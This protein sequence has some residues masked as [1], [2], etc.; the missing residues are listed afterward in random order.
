M[1]TTPGGPH[2]PRP[3]N[4]MQMKLRANH[5]VLILTTRVSARFF[6]LLGHR[7]F[8]ILVLLCVF[9]LFHLH[10]RRNLWT[11]WS[12]PHSTR[13]TIIVETAVLI[14]EEKQLETRC[15]NSI[16]NKKK[17]CKGMIMLKESIAD[18][19]FFFSFAW[20]KT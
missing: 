13:S 20:F 12:L 18:V 11:L 4:L 6:F 16:V 7:S 8:V 5:M 14:Y 19:H 17:R 9:N 10:G 1:Q 2:R 15:T 3:R